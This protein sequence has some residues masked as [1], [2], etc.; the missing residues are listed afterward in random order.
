MSAVDILIS[1]LKESAPVNTVV[2]RKIY[3]IL[4]P[5]DTQPPFIVVHLIDQ[6]DMARHLAGSGKYWRSVVQVD[7][8]YHGEIAG[9]SSLVFELGEKVIAALDGTVKAAVTGFT[10]TYSDVDI[11]HGGG[12][13]SD[14]EQDRNSVRRVIR[15]GINWRNA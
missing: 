15:F 8:L 1:L 14:Y 4:A 9:A 12:D 11:M 5:Q 10:G 2:D 7:C 6:M 13:H 3:P